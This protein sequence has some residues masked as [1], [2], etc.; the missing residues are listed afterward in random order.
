MEIVEER[1]ESKRMNHS[2]IQILMQ[3]KGRNS[4]NN[5]GGI[6][7]AKN[8]SRLPLQATQSSFLFFLLASLNFQMRI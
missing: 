3:R 2:F 1:R 4:N 6:I 8:I 5:V 7:Y